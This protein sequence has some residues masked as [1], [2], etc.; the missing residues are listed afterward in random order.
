MKFRAI[1]EWGT[2]LSSRLNGKPPYMPTGIYPF[3][4]QTRGRRTAGDQNKKIEK[5]AETKPS[6]LNKEKG[7]VAAFRLDPALSHLEVP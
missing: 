7:L 5:A 6:R 1:L 4:A 3:G 2:L